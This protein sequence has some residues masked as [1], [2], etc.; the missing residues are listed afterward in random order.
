MTFRNPLY[1]HRTTGN[2]KEYN[3]LELNDLYNK[4][5][6]AF[7]ANPS[8]E[9]T[10]VNSG[11]NLGGITETQVVAS[12]ARTNNRSFN[13]N[14]GSLGGVSTYT[15]TYDRIEQTVDSP[16]AVN[17]FNLSD[18]KSTINTNWPVYWESAGKDSFGSDTYHIKPMTDSDFL[19]TFC[20]PIIQQFGNP[21]ADPLYIVA[22]SNTIQYTDYSLVS[23]TPVYT[24]NTAD[25][26]AYTTGNLAE[27]V[28]QSVTHDYFLYRKNPSQTTQKF[29]NVPY[30]DSAYQRT[31]AGVGFELNVIK[32]PYQSTYGIEI[33]DGGT[34]Y[35]VSDNFIVLGSVLGGLD[36]YNDLAVYADSVDPSTG[37]ILRLWYNTFKSPGLGNEAH[38]PLTHDDSGNLVLMTKS[39]FNDLVLKGIE[40]LAYNKPG[41]QIRFF[42]DQGQQCGTAITDTR[43]QSPTSARRNQQIGDN[44]I[45]QTVPTGGTATPVATH[46]LG[47]KIT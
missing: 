19:D 42:W 5:K 20:T 8:V 12:P 13:N 30:R 32:Y 16:A 34:G 4:G 23:A 38:P 45:S 31:V 11:G 6:Q 15:V 18:Y 43:I 2:I 36:S 17:N 14:T 29:I 37:E 9:L 21:A 35:Q 22:D 27:A 46:Y 40:Y 47:V 41:N 10:V 1:Y 26:A 7:I 24:D 25:I 39:K 28:V 3:I 44:Y 33:K